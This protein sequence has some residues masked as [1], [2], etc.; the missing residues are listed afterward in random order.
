M[1][2]TNG[3]PLIQEMSALLI[4]YIYNFNNLFAQF[5]EVVVDSGAH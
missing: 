2:A 5:V 3:K 1:P 4:K